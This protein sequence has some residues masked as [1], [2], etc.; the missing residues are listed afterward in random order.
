[1][2]LLLISAFLFISSLSALA[3][4]ILLTDINMGFGIETF[5]S[6]KNNS[7]AEENEYYYG[8]GA[9]VNFGAP[10][11]T[12]VLNF[13]DD[14]Y[15]KIGNYYVMDTWTAQFS[16]GAT[17]PLS[18]YVSGFG[19]YGL[20]FKKS[21]DHQGFG[22]ILGARA[23]FNSLGP[24]SYSPMLGVSYAGF[25]SKVGATFAEIGYVYSESEDYPY[26]MI[27]F[28]YNDVPQDYVDKGIGALGNLISLFWNYSF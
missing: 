5:R 22:I 1:M 26:S 6:L 24:G 4:P 8:L 7:A 17:A 20:G 3:Q 18:F 10:L 23:F 14:Y 2:R 19:D 13:S 21:L 9:T 15:W 28:R 27:G 25:Q 11:V 16:F 12:G